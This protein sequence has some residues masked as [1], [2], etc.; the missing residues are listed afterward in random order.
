MIET[1]ASEL[2]KSDI[3]T[4]DDSFNSIDMSYVKCLFDDPT[5]KTTSTEK[6]L[7]RRT[8]AE[9][10]LENYLYTLALTLARILIRIST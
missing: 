10:N 8:G 9:L 1:E 7:W 4:I 3:Y 6:P 2:E 5:I